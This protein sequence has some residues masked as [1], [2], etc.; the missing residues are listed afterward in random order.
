[1][2]M[3]WQQSLAFQ[4]FLVPLDFFS[5]ICTFSCEE[6]ESIKEFFRAFWRSIRD[7]Q[8]WLHSS[9]NNCQNKICLRLSWSFFLFWITDAEKYNLVYHIELCGQM[10]IKEDRYSRKY[11]WK[12]FLFIREFSRGK[13]CCKIYYW[14]SYWLLIKEALLFSFL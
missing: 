4:S 8:G 13:W 11:K 1:M 2:V 9:S 12:M 10:N 3:L 6:Q 5:I 7:L 14:Y